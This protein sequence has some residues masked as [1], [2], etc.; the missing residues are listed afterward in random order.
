LRTRGITVDGEVIVLRDSAQ[1]ATLRS[2]LH[3][4][5]TRIADVISPP[6]NDV[7]GAILRPSQN[8]IAEHV[9]KTL[10][11][12]RRGTGGWSTGI[13]VERRYL[14]DVAGID[15]T[16]FLLRDASGL[17]PQNL[18][19]P[20]MVIALL[21]HARSSPWRD[22]FVEALPGPGMEDSTLENRLRELDG[23]LRAK[24]G[25]ITNVNSL[26][27]YITD[28]DGRTLAFSI[29]TNGSG[30]SS[31]VVRQG[32]DRIVLAIAREGQGQ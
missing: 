11:A 32:I 3:V 7:V 1:A 26:S 25:S 16:A 5:Y 15:S 27:G 8:W 19:T 14:I 6:L 31:A 20:D 4:G 12:E 17:S 30:V 21:E 23:R 13:D 18:M 9:L 28:T 29:L 24:T 22:R 2:N 10:G